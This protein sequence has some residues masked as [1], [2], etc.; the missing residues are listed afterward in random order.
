MKP[1]QTN[2]S[3]TEAFSQVTGVKSHMGTNLSPCISVY[4]YVQK[5]HILLFHCS[6]E[7]VVDCGVSLK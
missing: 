4:K 1:N 6:G 5:M 3:K 7:R 2:L